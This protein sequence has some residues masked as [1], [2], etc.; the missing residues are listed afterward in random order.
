MAGTLSNLMHIIT[1][2]LNPLSIWDQVVAVF[3]IFRPP[4]LACATST[5][6]SLSLLGG[7][8]VIDNASAAPP[9]HSR[10]Q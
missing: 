4:A 7:G 9:S 5:V 2:H 6:S 1:S 10:D 8:A 3:L